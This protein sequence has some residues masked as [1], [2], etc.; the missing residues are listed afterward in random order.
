MLKR[1]RWCDYLPRNLWRNQK[2]D[3]GMK[4]YILRFTETNYI[5][6]TEEKFNSLE[7]VDLIAK[8]ENNKIY[9]GKVFS[10]SILNKELS[11]KMLVP[12]ENFEVIDE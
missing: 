6:M 1:H 8:D 11:I 2:E 10:V 3:N 5:E 4:K 9:K 7:N 12:I